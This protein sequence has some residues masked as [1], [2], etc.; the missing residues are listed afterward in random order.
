MKP[1][2]IGVFEAKT[3]LSDL[4]RRVAGG[5]TFLLTNRGQPVAELRPAPENKSPL[6]RGCA[7]RKGFWMA[8]DFDAPLDDMQDYM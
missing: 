6:V 8:D 1:N 2:E 4:L 7:N 5:E 3:H